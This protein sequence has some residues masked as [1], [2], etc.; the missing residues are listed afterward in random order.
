MDESDYIESLKV[1][2]EIYSSFACKEKKIEK[3][4]KENLQAAVFQRLF[5]VIFLIDPTLLAHQSTYDFFT[6]FSSHNDRLIYKSYKEMARRS[7]Q[8]EFLAGKVSGDC[9]KWVRENWEHIFL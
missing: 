8:R 6:P 2:D 7:L 3:L 5:Q 9:C 1:L 4:T